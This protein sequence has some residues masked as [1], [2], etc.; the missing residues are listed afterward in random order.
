MI[1]LITGAPGAGKTQLLVALLLELAKGRKIYCDGI[2]EL[3]IDHEP[4]DKPDDWPAVVPDGCAV[5]VDECQRIWRPRGSGSRVPLS[6]EALETHRHRGLDFFLITQHP[7]L[8]DANIRRLVGR[9]LHLRDTGFFGRWL[10]EWPECANPETFKSC[11]NKKKFSLNKKVFGLYKSASLHVKPVRGIPRVAFV[12]GIA[13]VVLAGLGYFVY[14]NISGKLAA[15]PLAAAAAAS[16]AASGP[17]AVAGPS[18]VPVVPVVPGGGVLPGDPSPG[19]D[20]YRT[21]AAT[22]P[23]VIGGCW[24][25]AGDCWCVTNEARPRIVQPAACVAVALGELQPDPARPVP[26]PPVVERGGVAPASSGEQG[27]AAPTSAEHTL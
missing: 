17:G 6:I 13:L 2:P 16:R 22:M 27:A 23:A 26:T 8:V 7:N 12:L 15:N 14:R 25:T 1:T 4:L 11:T 3:Q 20:L 18:V 24:A 5:V 9:H 19:W 21:G 10:Y